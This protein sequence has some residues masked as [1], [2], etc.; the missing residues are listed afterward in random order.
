M[1]AT[2]VGLDVSSQSISIA[3]LRSD[4]LEVEEHRIANTPEAVRKLVARWGDP[5]RIR[6]CYEAGPT[7]YEL[8]RQLASLGIDC[9]VIAPTLT[10]RRP[11]EH[12]KT[13]RRDARMLCR[14]HRAGELTSIHI[15]RP[16]GT[17]SPSPSGS[18][19]CHLLV[20]SP[21]TSAHHHG[22]AASPHRVET[23]TES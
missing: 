13:D 7:G 8:Q 14:L 21:S 9:A 15:P 19:R 18:R 2:C 3:L 10:P 4:A 12:V 20:R 5:A 1:A 11:G 22:P 23:Q 16:S 17:S 6:A